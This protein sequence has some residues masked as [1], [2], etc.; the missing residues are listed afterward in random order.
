MTIAVNYYRSFILNTPLQVQVPLLDRSFWLDLKSLSD[1]LDMLKK[2]KLS[3]ISWPQ[4]QTDCTAHFSISHSNTAIQ[5]K[6]YV[7][8]DRFRSRQRKI[9]E[10][11][12][13]DNCVE[14]FIAFNKGLSYYNLEFN[15]F[16]N[17]KVAYGSGRENRTFLSEDAIKKIAVWTSHETVQEAF[18]WVI[19]L[20]IPIAVFEFSD[21]STFEKM[22]CYGNFYKCGDE[23][24][25]PHFL[26]WNKIDAPQ[27]D[28]HKPENFGEI[29][30]L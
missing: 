17:A 5:L 4:Y 2:Q 11:V 26:S 16:G 20:E 24:P 15:C 19:V 23:L 3:N 14:F 22:S 25:E 18:N 10:D 28:F 27:P 6:F 1:G 29:T 13:N 7:K 8:D 9:N 30:F 12:N 21:L